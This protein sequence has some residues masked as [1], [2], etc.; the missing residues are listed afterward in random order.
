[1]RR[2][3]AQLYPSDTILAQIS[4]LT[5]MVK[6]LQKQPTIHEVK[7]SMSN[8][9]DPTW[10]KHPNFSWK[11]QNNTL[12]PSTSTQ[13]G[14]HS[15]PRQ[16]QQDYQQPNNHRTLENTLNT[17]MTQTSAYMARTDQFIQKI[18]AFMDRIEMRMQNQ[19]ASL[20]SLE[21]QV[22]QISQVLKSRPMGGFPSDTKVAKG[23]THEQCKAI[24]TRSGKVLKTPTE[25][26]QGE[27]T[28][29]NSKVAN[30]T[31]SPALADT[32]VS[33]GEDYNNPFEPEES[34][35]NSSTS[36]QTTQKGHTGGTKVTRTIPTKVQ[37]AET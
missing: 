27:A 34:S 24:L 31:D 9:Y 36:T 14:Y 12:N 17:F 21:N 5:K 32:P 23:A 20:K 3:T 26:K 33:A 8:T 18:D 19:E 30:D 16:N 37:K 1:M 28:T 6:N 10:K 15:Q 2:G 22:G 7:E 29:A 13:Q 11:N 25:N 35:D 4:A